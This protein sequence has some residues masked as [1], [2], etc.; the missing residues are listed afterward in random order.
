MN[1]ASMT[2][3]IGYHLTQWSEIK[4]ARGYRPTIRYNILD[5]AKHDNNVANDEVAKPRNW[6]DLWVIVMHMTN[7][8]SGSYESGGV[9]ED[10]FGGESLAIY[11][12][13]WSM[14]VRRK[15]AIIPR[16]LDICSHSNAKVVLFRFQI[17]MWRIL[18][19]SLIWLWLCESLV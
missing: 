4:S 8:V 11:V 14:E 2:S 17:S 18:K 12:S 1:R 6:L 3:N 19:L 10:I 15:P 5:I 7:A 16:A 9:K 13:L